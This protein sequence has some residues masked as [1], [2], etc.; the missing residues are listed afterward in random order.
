M[1]LMYLT[2]ADPGKPVGKQFLGAAIVRASNIF[3]AAQVAWY[4]GLNPAGGEVY[5]LDVPMQ[6][7]I[8][9]QYIE[10]FLTKQDIDELDKLLGY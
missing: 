10:R 1:K 5:A 4:L 6:T 7:K 9:A 8:P 2:F 3:E